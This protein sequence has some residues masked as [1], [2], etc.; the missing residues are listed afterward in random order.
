MINKTFS[1]SYFSQ[2]IKHSSN[3]G[4]TLIECL[5]AIFIIALTSASIGPVAILAVATRVQNQKSEQALQLAQ[6]EIDRVRLIVEREATYSDSELKLFESSSAPL[7]TEIA[8]AVGPPTALVNKT[9]WESPTYSPASEFAGKE[10][11]TNADGTPDFVVQSFRGESVSVTPTGTT[12]AMPVAF[13]MGV[14]VYDY[15]AVTNSDGTIVSGLETDPAGLA[16]T[17]G[18]GERGRK[19]LAV[20]YTQIVNSDN[21]QSLCGFMDYLEAALPPTMICPP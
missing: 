3:S 12:V 6:G 14:R 5:V 9:S 7:G 13:D 18:E 8:T 4:L 19:P 1:P 11:D 16:F 21:P 10:I 20:V 17:S 2:Q 15:G